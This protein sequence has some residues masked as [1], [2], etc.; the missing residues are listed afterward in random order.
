[1]RV[2]FPHNYYLSAF[3]QTSD[4]FSQPTDNPQAVVSEK[5]VFTAVDNGAAVNNRSKIFARDAVDVLR[6]SKP[7]VDA[8]AIF[9]SEMSEEATSDIHVLMNYLKEEDP[10]L[11]W[12]AAGQL[13]SIGADLKDVQG[14]LIEIAEDEEE[15]LFVRLA[16]IDTLGAVRSA[17]AVPLLMKII[18][19]DSQDRQL[20]LSAMDALANI[21]E[22]PDGTIPEVIYIKESNNDPDVK[23]A[24]DESEEEFIRQVARE[25]LEELAY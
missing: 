8:C 17:G 5:Q 16:A 3:H 18:M 7:F 10:C 21:G 13:G 22:A 15:L 14:P 24:E 12:F 19:D 23:I 4:N 6:S 1:M 11:R 9:V 25:A 20:V 2:E